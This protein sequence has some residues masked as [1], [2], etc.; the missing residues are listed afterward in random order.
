MYLS[1]ISVI[2]VKANSRRN[3]VANVVHSYVSHAIAVRIVCLK[4]FHFIESRLHAQ[5][6]VIFVRSH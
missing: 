1:K 2:Y 6:R 3:D 5:H 4:L